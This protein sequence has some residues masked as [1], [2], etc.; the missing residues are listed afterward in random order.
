V[1]EIVKLFNKSGVRYLLIGGQ[2]MRLHGMPRFSMD[3]DFFIPAKD[4]KNFALINKAMGKQ[5]DV[6]LAPLGKHGENFVQTYQ[7]K[8]GIL[9]FHLGVPGLPDFEAAERQSVMLKTEGDVPIKCACGKDLLASKQSAGRAV[10]A[11]DV[12]FLQKKLKNGI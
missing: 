3:W 1:E 6:P 12:E 11:Q 10:D 4:E 9:Q 8:W 5:L 7:T 2:A